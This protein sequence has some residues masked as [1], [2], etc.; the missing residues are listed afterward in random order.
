MNG[1]V[2]YPVRETYRLIE[3]GPTVLI[4]T[5]DGVRDNIMTNAFNMPVRHDGI[6][7]VIVG[8]WD[9][10]FEVKGGQALQTCD[11]VLMASTRQ[12]SRDPNPPVLSSYKLTRR[13]DGPLDVQLT[14]PDA[15]GF[16]GRLLS[17]V[18]LLTLLPVE[19]D[20]RT[21]GSTIE[22]RF[23]FAGMRGTKPDDELYVALD[24][25]LRGFIKK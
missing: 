4:S 17:R 12:Q 13:P 8:T 25:M 1:F 16:L 6:L 7:A 11:P 2:P 14:A 10:S 19:M 18:S 21:V 3:P 23:A 20:I 22:D 15:P 9:A 24:Q 5:S